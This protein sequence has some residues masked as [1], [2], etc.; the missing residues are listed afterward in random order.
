MQIQFLN[1]VSNSSINNK[2]NKVKI[3]N[4]SH[5]S[6]LQHDTFVKT[7]EISFKAG[8]SVANTESNIV[9]DLVAIGIVGV[10][11]LLSI[12][13]ATELAKKES[14]KDIFLPDGTYFMNTDEF[15]LNND[16]IIADGDDGIF[17][18]KGTGIDIDANKYDIADIEHGIYK[19][20][21]G[22]VDIDLLHNK[23]ID[24]QN[25]I[26][27]DP[28]RKISAIEVDGHLEQIVLPSFGSGT[29]DWNP[30][31]GI[32]YSGFPP[33]REYPWDAQTRSEFIKAH[34]GKTPEEFFGENAEQSDIARV[35]G[36]GKIKPD[37]YRSVFQ[38]LKDFFIDD[39][40]DKGYDKTRIYDIFGN[41][42]IKVKDHS[43]N[44]HN[45]SLNDEMMRLFQEKHIDD[46]SIVKIAQFMND[47]KLENYI[48]HLYP[49]FKA[50]IRPE[51]SNV[52]EF[53]NSLSDNSDKINDIINIDDS[54]LPVNTAMQACFDGNEHVGQDDTIVLIKSIFKGLFG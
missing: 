6:G 45:L 3:Y 34:N 41:Q 14:P 18:V 32:G 51:F 47:H 2:T 53:L 35:L 23:Y 52:D 8:S 9:N 44:I 26:F 50:L 37:D 16:K 28:E 1:H 29:P 20:Y 27:I 39:S 46:E 40:L 4:S 48:S 12:A 54:G 5:T 43:G 33:H 38:K 7:N 13:A 15:K 30:G 22:S 25:G 31:G 11:L 24:T 49:D 19:N 42:I 36:Y 10:P 21:D 17:K